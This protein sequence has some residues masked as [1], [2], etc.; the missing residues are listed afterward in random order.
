M[1]DMNATFLAKQ[2]WN[3]LT[4]PDIYWVTIVQGK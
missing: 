1:E 2:G 3:I 4:Q